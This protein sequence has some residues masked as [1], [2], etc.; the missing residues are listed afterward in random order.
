MVWPQEGEK[1]LPFHLWVLPARSLLKALQRLPLNPGQPEHWGP[2]FWDPRGL[3][4]AS[5]HPVPVTHLLQRELSQPPQTGQLTA[6]TK[7][8][9]NEWNLDPRK[10]TASPEGGI[11]GQEGLPTVLHSPLT[12]TPHRHSCCESL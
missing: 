6:Q 3:Q 5:G 4:Y 7:N 8:S 12:L 9:S 2:L 11:P 10:P 1:P